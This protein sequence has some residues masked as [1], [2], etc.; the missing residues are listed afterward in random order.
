MTVNDPMWPH[1][2]PLWTAFK[3]AG[4]PMVLAGGYGLFL[5]QA[6]L[7]DQQAMPVVVALPD[8]IDATPRVTKDLDIIIGLELLASVDAQ[9]VIARTMKANQFDVADP[10]W[11]FKKHLDG[12]RH[13]MVDFH[14]MLPEGDSRLKADKLRVKHRRS[15]GE[16]GVH[17]RRNPEAVGSETHPFSFQYNG[18]DIAVPNPVSWTVMKLISMRD[19]HLRSQDMERDEELRQQ[20]G[21]QAMKHARDVTRIIAMTT[22]NERDRVTEVINTIREQPPFHEAIKVC[23]QYF[24]DVDAW[25]T[26][27]VRSMWREEHLRQIRELLNAWFQ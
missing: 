18:L 1:F 14:A 9:G 4:E 12:D 5:K 10:R 21:A 7:M 8:W 27:A 3:N 2:Q 11:Q 20:E 15:L 16:E 24:D 22:L 6:W 26:R 25:G 17:G 13:M 19:R 23:N